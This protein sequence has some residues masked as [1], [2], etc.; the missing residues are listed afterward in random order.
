M[1]PLW[2][3]VAAC[4][5]VLSWLG[6]SPALGVPTDGTIVRGD[7]GAKLDDYLQRLS[8][9]GYSGTVLAAK[10]NEIILQKGYGL[11][12]REKKR[13]M[14]P[15]TVISV[16]SITKQFTAAAILK[17]EMQGKLSVQDPITKFFPGVPEDKTGITLH[18]LLTHT[19]G[20]QSDFG[21]DFEKVSRDEIVKRAVGSKLRSRPGERYAYANSGYSL[22]GAVVENVSGHGYEAYLHENLLKPAGMGRTGYLIPMWKPEELAVGYEH[23]RRWGT[24]LERPWAQDGPYWNL[25]CNGGILSTVGDMF[26]WHLAL[27]GEKLLSR[28][29]KQKLFTP[30]VSEDQRGDSS[31]AYGWSIAKTDRGTR[32]IG[33]NGSNGIFYAEFRR[34]V[35]DGVVIYLASNVDELANGRVG[36]W[37]SRIVFGGEVPTPPRVV[38]AAAPLP[39]YAGIYRLRSGGRLIAAVK[40][41]RLTITAEGA[42]AFTLVAA[43]D[44]GDSKVLGALSERTSAIMAARMNKDYQPLYKAL[45]ARVPLARLEEIA[46]QSLREWEEEQGPYQGFEVLGSVPTGNAALTYVRL[47]FARGTVGLCYEWDKDRLAGVRP[48][49]ASPSTRTFLPTSATEFAAFSVGVPTVVRVRFRTEGNKVKGLTVRARDGDVEATKGE[50]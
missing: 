36:S 3:I 43:G 44:R 29:A 33:H 31:Y 28:A 50:S 38:A 15:D 4:A 40:D 42:D 45:G 22:L 5:F 16:G 2:L 10:D 1:R 34:Y 9:W 47:K 20:L 26:K 24:E 6:G 39:Q 32:L 7:L 30:H 21:D 46:A 37:L 14:T 13:P 48:V 19:A 41:G 11:A 35:D 49:P 23:G 8:D 27:E 18:H 17:L 12:D 25:R